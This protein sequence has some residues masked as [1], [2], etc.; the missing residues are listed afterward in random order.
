MTYVDYQTYQGKRVIYMKGKYKGMTI[1]KDY[2]VNQVRGTLI[3]VCSNYGTLKWL[4]ASN[5][6]L[7][8]EARGDGWTTI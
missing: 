7:P 4:L 6:S 1:G 2:R 8:E 3:R 5:F